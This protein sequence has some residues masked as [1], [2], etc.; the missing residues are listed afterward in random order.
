M[1][2]LSLFFTLLVLLVGGAMAALV[3]LIP[4]DFYKQKI[5]EQASIMLGRELQINGPVSIK[6]FPNLQARAQNV[7]LANPPGFS[8]ANFATMREMRTS[9]ALMP[10]F[11]RKV[12]IKEFILVEP[13]VVLE[14]RRNGAVNWAIGNS[15]R[16]GERA[17]ANTG[18]AREPGA[19]PLEASLGEVRLID[20]D[21]KIIDRVK[22]KR[23]HLEGVNLTLNMPSLDGPMKADGQLKLNN[24]AYTLSGMLGGLKPF[25]E[26]EQTPLKLKLDNTLYS[27]TF[28][29]AFDEGSKIV[30]SGALRLN[31]P[32]V[33]KLAAFYDLAL[34]DRPNTFGPFIISGTARANTKRFS[35]KGAKVRFD[36]ITGTGSFGALFAGDKP[37]LTGNLNIARLDLTPYLPPPA[38]PGRGIAPWNTTPFDLGMLK[39]V[40]SR[41]TLSLDALQMRKIKIGKSVMKTALVNGRLQ[42]DLSEMALYDGQ[43]SAKIVVNGRSTPPSFSLGANITGV[44][45]QPLLRDSIKFKR[46]AG[47]GDSQF[48]L[49]GRGKTQ[50]EVMQSLSGTGN[51][52]LKDG[53]IIGINLAAVLRN[54]QSFITT[55]ALSADAGASKATDFTDLSA[56]FVVKDGIARTDDFLMLAPVLRVPGEGSLDIGGQLVD[57]SLTP[58][59]VASLEGQGG[60]ADLLGLKAPFR[61]YGPWNNV[62]AGLDTR[63]LKKKAKKRTK[64][65]IGKLIDKQVGGDAGSALKS[66]FGVPT[67]PPPDADNPDQKQKTDEEVAV[68]T[69][70]SLFKKKKKKKKKTPDQ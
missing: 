40:D 11:S 19:L 37:K 65:E 47:T 4:T 52:R 8:E 56:S 9:I 2:K 39:A 48:A 3:Y 28:D 15:E 17:S 6:L 31:I 51:L 41:F 30:A 69:L 10:L 59:A 27:L 67:T 43:G 5:E 32:S 60:S 35:F 26:G 54:A 12:E 33:R 62:K 22:D 70:I 49:L 29:G 24:S 20:G 58:R 55:G 64:K 25:L 42:A 44:A 53:Q 45:F 14:K 68:D 61:I 50:A 46:L 34:M 57:F 66:L 16:A 7:T 63:L 13:V 36:D 18:F 1:R 21:I 23:H 38:A